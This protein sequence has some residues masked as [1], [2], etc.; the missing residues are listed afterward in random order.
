MNSAPQAVTGMLGLWLIVQLVVLLALLLGGLYALF[1]LSRA[2]AGLD[3][4][5]SAVEQ[6]VERENTKNPPPAPSALFPDAMRPVPIPSTP[7]PPE[8]PRY[9]EQSISPAREESS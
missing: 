2:A 5:A 6:W 3:R 8:P 1:C 4:L 9:P 7:I